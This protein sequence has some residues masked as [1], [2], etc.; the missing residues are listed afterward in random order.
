[1]SRH[2][3]S[4]V[5]LVWMLCVIVAF[6]PV[7]SIAFEPQD[8]DASLANL[9]GEIELDRL[10]DL[11]AARLG[12]SLQY[13]KASLSKSVTI[14][15][16]EGLTDEAVWRLTNQLLIK[17][18]F[19]VVQPPESDILQIVP[20]ADAKNIARIETPE[21]AR[22]RAPLVGYMRVRVP[23]QHQ[24]VKVI[25]D[26]VTPLLNKSTSSVDALGES[27]QILIAAPTTT[28]LDVLDLIEMLD[29]GD[30]SATV[31]VITPNR[32]PPDQLAVQIG[33]IVESLNT[34]S[35]KPVPG[36]LVPAASGEALVLIAPPQEIEFWMSL[37]DQFD[38]RGDVAT[39]IY[40][41]RHFT[42][43][44]V[45]ALIEQTCKEPPPQGS[46]H[47]WNIVDDAL[48]GT[49]IVTAT[50]AEHA[51]IDDLM[52][53]LD[54]APGESRRPMR[55]YPIRNR[56]V[57]E[58]LTILQSLV[59]QGAL[60][61]DAVLIASTDSTR[62]YSPI[63]T[64]AIR[65]N[66]SP[67]G[68]PSTP[69]GSAS[70]SVYDPNVTLPRIA[71]RADQAPSAPQSQRLE[72]DNRPA[73]TDPVAS[74]IGEQRVPL[75][76]T[77]DEGTNT[78]IAIGDPRIL[79]QLEQLIKQLD[80]RQ[81]QVKIEVLVV[82]LTDAD[83]L[84]LGVEIEKL[85]VSG[86]TLI[87]LASL[88]GLSTGT[89]AAGNVSARGPGFSGV[90][91]NPGDFSVVVR[92]LQT[93]NDGRTVNL[94][95]ILVNNNQSGTLNS[96]LQQPFT[97]TNASD[98]VATT[99]F[100]G[101]Q[102][103]G[104][105]V[106]VKPQIAEGDHL[107]LEYSV[108]ISNFVGES[109]SPE[110]PPPRQQNSLQSIVTI[111]DGYTIAVGGIEILSDAKATSQVPWIGDVPILG[112]LFK[113]RSNSQSRTRFYVFIRSTVLRHGGFEDLKYLSD[114]D[115]ARAGIDDGWP[116]VEPRLIR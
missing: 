58:I 70:P 21:S 75:E 39:R 28:V 114:T 29:A 40:R 112:E 100:G 60:R 38:R 66:E 84:D 116:V 3:Q 12:L 92:A 13:P 80:V 57:V 51:R 43:S 67:G 73:A 82:G 65:P 74:R 11:S 49:L 93:I 110:I 104:T 59:E 90:V 76:L 4:R 91:L 17:E 107:V 83:T 115:M 88:F 31:R 94:P 34:L 10:V 35:G 44:E 103:A 113:N 108:A 5:V 25:V 16:T 48:T 96:V 32:V 77:A 24:P 1:M 8:D 53:R 15:Q 68:Q 111:P 86:D 54:A 46:G 45:R 27:N 42:L 95:H 62:Q 85:E 55:A 63:S 71:S 101:T 14:R 98:T 41:P 102:D 87:S 22:E 18:N 52:K 106:T 61:T 19:T 105:T 78:L 69:P 7:P 89:T 109:S 26:A 33:S 30:R 72:P 37:I 56:G 36:R 20:L 99:S 79:E 6:C 81:P 9:A 97:S 64:R 47:Q 23:L 2:E 50:P